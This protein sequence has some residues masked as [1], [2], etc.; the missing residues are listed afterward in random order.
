MNNSTES[1]KNLKK[2]NFATKYKYKYKYKYKNKYKNKYKYKYKLLYTN[3]HLS[4]D[5]EAS[6]T[7]LT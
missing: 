7:T 2:V 5:E 6:N 4:E 3:S 1:V